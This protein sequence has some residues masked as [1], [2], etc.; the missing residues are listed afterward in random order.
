V[1]N[2]LEINEIAVRTEIKKAGL[3]AHHEKANLGFPFPTC[4]CV[5]YYKR[6]HCYRIADRHH[7]GH[8]ENFLSH[9]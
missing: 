3:S 6:D 5:R 2:L 4:S 8:R 7:D 9:S 1:D